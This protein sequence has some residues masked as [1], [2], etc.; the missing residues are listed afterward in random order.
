MRITLG[1]EYVDTVDGDKDEDILGDED[2]LE[3]VGFE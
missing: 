1:S 2:E 3:S